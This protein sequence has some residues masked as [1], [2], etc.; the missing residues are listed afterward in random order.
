MRSL[1]MNAL[2][3]IAV[4]DHR[5][6]LLGACLAAALV[7]GAALATGYALYFAP[8]EPQSGIGPGAS[9]HA[10]NGDTPE[11]IIDLQTRNAGQVPVAI[12]PE[13]PSFWI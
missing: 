13:E 9:V 3:T 11:W 2:R 8:A 10:K 4:T 6:T 1:R 5:R 7:T 12:D